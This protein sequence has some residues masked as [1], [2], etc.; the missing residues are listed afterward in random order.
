[1]MAITRRDDK[2]ASF[3]RCV[4]NGYATTQRR[5]KGALRA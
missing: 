1:M 3:T 2:D 4:R 5:R